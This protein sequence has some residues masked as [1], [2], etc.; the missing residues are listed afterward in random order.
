MASAALERLWCAARFPATSAAVLGHVALPSHR[1]AGG[2]DPPMSQPQVLLF[3]ATLHSP[4]IEKL[5]VQICQNPMRLD[6]KGHEAAPETVDHVVV[7][8]RSNDLYIILRVVMYIRLGGFINFPASCTSGIWNLSNQ[9]AVLQGISTADGVLLR[10]L[11]DFTGQASFVRLRVEIC[12]KPI[13][14]VPR[15]D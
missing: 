2:A 1:E 5:A 10:L 14:C 8:V 12:L 3:S 6:L 15:S 9:D 11:W 7:Q 4:A 13:G